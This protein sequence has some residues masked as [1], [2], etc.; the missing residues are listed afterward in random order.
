M[1]LFLKN[2]QL[3]MVAMLVFSTDIFAGMNGMIMPQSKNS[4]IKKKTNS[5]NAIADLGSTGVQTYCY[6]NDTVIHACSSAVNPATMSRIQNDYDTAIN[7][8]VIPKIGDSMAFADGTL[9][10]VASGK[11]SYQHSSNDLP[12]VLEAGSDLNKIA[13][14]NPNIRDEWMKQYGVLLGNLKGINPG[15]I[16][17]TIIEVGGAGKFLK[18][19]TK[20]NPVVILPMSGLSYKLVAY[21]EN[22][23]VVLSNKDGP[24]GY[25][26]LMNTPE[27]RAICGLDRIN[28]RTPT[29]SVT[30]ATD[31]KPAATNQ[32]DYIKSTNN[33]SIEMLIKASAKYKAG[34]ITK[35]QYTQ[36]ALQVSQ[37]ADYYNHVKATNTPTTIP[38]SVPVVP[39]GPDT[40][41][42]IS[43]EEKYAKAVCPKNPKFV[44]CQP[45]ANRLQ[46][47]KD[48]VAKA[49]KPMPAEW[50]DTIYGDGHGELVPEIYEGS[51][52]NWKQVTVGPFVVSCDEAVSKYGLFGGD[53]NKPGS[54]TKGS[55][56][57]F[58]D[59]GKSIGS[60]GA[61]IHNSYYV[62]KVTGEQ[63]TEADIN[64]EA[65]GYCQKI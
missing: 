27:I 4:V 11:M 33:S 10:R 43:T 7:G 65:I 52:A 40:T 63:M 23:K 2:I 9:T 25:N 57:E 12:L 36:V 1:I 45:K 39:A 14:Q 44:I 30:T 8:G 16:M 18:S 3:I 5:I 15:L 59:N 60:G 24:I 22:G 47:I 34:T 28:V 49:K 38:T 53:K 56:R 54:W 41:A 42:A 31:T 58:F 19:Y 26:E 46:Y 61:A 51:F 32:I 62:D 20:E 13:D 50:A 17:N 6:D 55:N 48:E 29:K 35:D 21:W 64:F 37:M